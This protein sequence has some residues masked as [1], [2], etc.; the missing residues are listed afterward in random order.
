MKT[1][2]SLAKRVSFQIKQD[3]LLQDALI[4]VEL[5]DG[6]LI[7]SGT[8]DRYVRKT[9][10]S[11]L[12]EKYTGKKE[13]KDLVVV[14]L[15]ESGKVSDTEI[16]N[17]IA[18]QLEKNL[19]GSFKNLTVSV[20]LGQVILD[21]TVKWNY[22]RTLAS[23]CLYDIDGI[24]SLENNIVIG[25]QPIA[26]IAEKDILAAIYREESITSEISVKIAD[27]KVIVFGSVASEAQKKLVAD[28][29]RQIPKVGE[30]QN[31]LKVS[32]GPSVSS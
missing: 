24:V 12:L 29:V 4:D 18:T 1:D 11:Q 15:P 28:I 19:G 16:A 21:G 5:Q 7:V 27:N 14:C 31:D 17:R 10:L 26:E 20:Q 3:P 25:N 6:Q 23:E 22:Q 30:V 9:R 32:V 8:V 13:I 2:E